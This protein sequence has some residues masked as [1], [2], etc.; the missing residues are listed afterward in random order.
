[1][2]NNAPQELQ[3]ER[4]AG[5]RSDGL[6]TDLADAEAGSAASESQRVLAGQAP[7]RRRW[8]ALHQAGRRDPL[9]GELPPAVDEGPAAHLDQ[10]MMQSK[11][12]ANAK[13]A[14]G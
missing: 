14:R 8:A 1:M 4:L 10:R 7:P 5:T 13:S 12:M 2:S 6:G 9:R 3:P 11:L